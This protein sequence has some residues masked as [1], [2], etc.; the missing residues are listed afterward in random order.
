MKLAS[1]TRSVS[2]SCHWW[3]SVTMSLSQI[4]MLYVGE[5]YIHISSEFSPAEFSWF[6]KFPLLYVGEGWRW[7][8]SNHCDSDGDRSF[9]LPVALLLCC[10]NIDNMM[11]AGSWKSL[12]SLMMLN[13]NLSSD[14][15]LLRLTQTDNFSPILTFMNHIM[16]YGCSSTFFLHFSLQQ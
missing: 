13:G 16:Y 3:K 4:N 5:Q 7:E 8:A 1:M 15:N 9:S 11:V 14:D 10:S 6:P 12:S 2:G